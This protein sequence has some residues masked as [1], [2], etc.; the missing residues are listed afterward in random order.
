MNTEAIS[1]DTSKPK[2]SRFKLHIKHKK[3]LALY[4]ILLVIPFLVTLSLDMDGKGFYLSAISIFNV[5]FMMAFFV[6]FPLGSRV[7]QISLFANIDWS[8]SKHKKIGQWIGI[9]FF[10]HPLFIL[11]PKFFQSVDD[12]IR[13]VIEIVVAP[14]MLTGLIAWVAMI[15]WVLTAVFK[16]RLRMSY[17][18]WRLTHLVGFVVIAV[19]A[20]LHIT[21]VGSHGQFSGA[22]NAIWWLLCVSSVLLV[23]Y[24]H[25]TKKRMILA[26]PF[27]LVDIKKVSSRDWKVVLE[28]NSNDDFSFEAG[29]FVWIN[30]GSSVFNLNDHPFSIASSTDELPRFSMVIRELGDYTSQL[31]TLSIGQEVFVDGPYGSMGLNES[32]DA[33]SIVLI[34]GGAGIGP[35]LSLLSELAANK[36]PRPIRLIYGNGDYQQMSLQD[37]VKKLESEMPDFSQQLVCME[38]GD[39]PDVRKGFVDQECIQ[40]VLKTIN[41]TNHSV[42]L[43]GPEGM[44]ASVQ[45]SLEASGI[46]TADI[47]FEQIS[48]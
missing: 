22:F 28:K 25:I 44:I 39:E 8:M 10:L 13:S 31:N 36:D 38:V 12:G 6:Q 41:G 5:I 16:N 37:E 30:T 43:C 45:K 34:A 20:T 2:P 35:M 40:S 46:P 18:T 23:A 4:A 11:A 42:Y 3:L 15:L 27:T 48:F 17:E 1:L 21:T 7:K 24:N 47:H 33:D 26:K 19:L 29:Q 32:K 14:Q 9:F